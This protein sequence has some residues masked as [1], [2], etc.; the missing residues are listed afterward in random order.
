MTLDFRPATRQDFIDLYGKPPSMTVKA[1][2]ASE[3]DKVVA[4]GGY[5][6]VNGMAVAFSDLGRP[7]PKR[8]VLKAAKAFMTFLKSM[9]LD[10]CAAVGSY[11]HTALQH[12]G[13]EPVGDLWRFRT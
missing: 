6:L 1:I 11:G 9:K 5:Y 3:N 12:F 10:I 13:F 7:L 4:I 2:V 8:D